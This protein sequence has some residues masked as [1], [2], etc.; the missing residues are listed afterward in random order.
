MLSH[1]AIPTKPIL[2]KDMSE[3]KMESIHFFLLS[4]WLISNH[5]EQLLKYEMM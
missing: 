3:K 4:H 2:P 1:S 5:Y